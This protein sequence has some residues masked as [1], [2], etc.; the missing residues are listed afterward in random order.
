MDLLWSASTTMRNPERTLSFLKTASEIEGAVWC[1]N[2]QM[3]YQ[4]LLIKNRYYTPTAKNLP[5]ELFALVQ[6]YSHDMTYEE[7]AEI[8]S[9]K[10]YVDAAMRGRTS[11][12]PLEK[13]GLVSLDADDNGLQR[14]RITEFGKMF[15][16]GKIDLGEMVFLSLLKAQYPNPLENGR[17]DYNI[18]PFIGT[19]RLIKKVN[20]ICVDR[21]LN[22]VG[23][24]RE[25][26]GIFVLSLKSYLRIDETAEKLIAFREKK[27]EIMGDKEKAAFVSDYIIDFLANF[28][29]PERNIKEY[30]DN[31]IRYLRLTK[32]IYIRGGGYYIDLEPRR[33]IEIEAI[34]AQDDASAKAFSLDEYK[35]YIS[36]INAYTLPFETE[37]KLRDI[38]NGII[39]ENAELSASLGLETASVS[40]PATK[41]ELKTQ[42]EKL[43]ERRTELQNLRIKQDF[44]ALDKI[45]EAIA[46]L[47]N[48]LNRRA[49]SGSK[50][51]VELEKWANVALNILNDATLIKPN[52]PLGDDNEPTFT[53]P[54]NV[55]DIECYYDG[56]GAIC[57]VTMLTGRDQ[58]YN[59]GQ[60]VMR[61]LRSFEKANSELSYCLFVAPRL[62]TDTINTFWTAVKYEY[63]GQRQ[64]IVPI[65]ITGLIEVLKI[66]RS[67]KAASKPFRKDD[68][69]SLYDRCVD[70]TDVSD[71]TRWGEHIG[72]AIVA[73][74]I[75]IL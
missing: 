28:Q 24:S 41:G 52:A 45:D 8:F 43:R 20:E 47:D 51:S 62:H 46:A 53:A 25:E 15:L 13:L 27:R 60:P 68:L 63:E 30:T 6:D 7:A 4:A 34:L 11:F 74:G 21:G 31:M 67:V 36:D 71:S 73:W 44:Q 19:L 9:K 48:T 50:P 33:M 66:V 37:S 1:D 26:F 16:A 39:K 56:F 57:E 23:I 49:L 2:T 61:H 29:N 18:K 75:D 22:A 59:E 72:Q 3:R 42:I 40:L 14:I 35:R 55:P 58:W 5:P 54:A 65:T 69:R 12:D 38:A 64:R 32:Y 70:I 17:G 10:Q